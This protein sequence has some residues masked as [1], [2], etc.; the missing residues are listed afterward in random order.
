MESFSLCWARKFLIK[1]EQ[2]T[3]QGELFCNLLKEH[4]FSYEPNLRPCVFQ[5]T[6]RKTIEYCKLVAFRNFLFVRNIGLE[7]D[8]SSIM[9]GIKV[10]SVQILRNGI[11]IPDQQVSV[12]QGIII[13][14]LVGTQNQVAPVKLESGAVLCSIPPLIF[15]I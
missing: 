12:S 7:R 5:E 6:G 14:N 13:G 10:L 1:K 3:C 4:T 15:G 9:L 11:F 8:S 2:T